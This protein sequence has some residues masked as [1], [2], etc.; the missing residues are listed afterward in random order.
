MLYI[1]VR[2]SA[3]GADIKPT[4]SQ[5]L[6]GYRVA[7][8]S[9][10]MAGP[11]CSHFLRMLGADVVKVESLSG[12][13]MR[14]Y[15]PF[16]EWDGM[17]PAF[18]AANAGKRSVAIDLKAAAGSEI[19]QRLIRQSDVVLENFRPG[20]MARLGLGYDVCCELNP[21]IIFCSVS[22]YGQS[23]HL[24]DYP[25]IDNILQAASG[26]M[27]ANGDEGDPPS[28][29]GWPVVDTYTGTL[30]AL[31]VVA[32][33]LRREREGRG[34]CID[35]SMLDASMVMLTS[36]VTPYLLTGQMLPR[37]GDTG[38]SGSPTAGLFTA[39]D[40]A[41]ISLGVVQ[42]NQF[43]ALCRA[44]DRSD[45]IGDARFATPVERMKP[46]NAQALRGMLTELIAT[47]DGTEWETLL[48][49]S[50]APCARVRTVGQACDE[51]R[52]EGRSLFEPVEVQLNSARRVEGSYINAGFEYASD[53][54]GGP[55]T[56]ASLGEHTREVLAELGYASAQIEQWIGSGVV[57]VAR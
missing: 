29:V 19:A 26:M 54:P 16:R 11:Y 49:R 30:A 1:P 9:H 52:V 4:M 25:A 20:V 40:G 39:R 32:A 57:R 43:A 44:V 28:R 27:S 22:G 37:T 41:R 45:W 2:S 33:L 51:L 47:R 55:G 10:V 24:R 34:E 50:G 8:F 23:G 13:A 48:N 56:V 31:A 5:P 42:N 6:K 18:V 38:Y 15:G 53:G 14:N 35:V 46:E 21:K 12:D 17:A 3:A 36:L 7:D